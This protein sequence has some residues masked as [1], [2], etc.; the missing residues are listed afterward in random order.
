MRLKTILCATM[1]LCCASTAYAVETPT[2]TEVKEYLAKALDPTTEYTIAIDYITKAIYVSDELNNAAL[3]E[4]ALKANKVIQQRPVKALVVR[5]KEAGL[6]SAKFLQILERCGGNTLNFFKTYELED[7]IIP[8]ATTRLAKFIGLGLAYVN[9]MEAKSEI[10]PTIKNIVL[11]EPINSYYDSLLH[12]ADYMIKRLY[13][14]GD[15]LISEQLRNDLVMTFAMFI[16]NNPM[17]DDQPAEKFFANDYPAI[18]L[19]FANIHEYAIERTM[20]SYIK[21]YINNTEF[22]KVE[23][24][25]LIDKMNKVS[26]VLQIISKR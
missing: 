23:P 18:N 5:L 14:H 25:M 24:T 10:E 19:K 26:N 2:E 1:I 17:I 21:G 3:L 13:H 16:S 4:E 11:G 8:E 12:Q 22:V 9:T 7:E 6:K 15:F 20:Q